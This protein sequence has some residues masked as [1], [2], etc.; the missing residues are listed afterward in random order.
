MSI[1]DLILS[2][3][4]L[5]NIVFDKKQEEDNILL[6]IGKQEIKLRRVFAEFISPRIS[7]IR[8]CDPT[9][10]TID[11]T[12]L[13]YDD[14]VDQL[15]QIFTTKLINIMN[16]LSSGYS[17]DLDENMISNFLL[18]SVILGN[19]ELY[20]KIFDKLTKE[21]DAIQIDEIVKIIQYFK[22]YDSISSIVDCN[23]YISHIASHFHAIDT[24]KLKQLQLSTLYLILRD[25]HLK[26]KSE[27]SLLDFIKEVL[28]SCKVESDEMESE[29]RKKF[30]EVVD[31][32]GLS[33]E[34]FSEFI[35]QLTVSEISEKLWDLL[36]KLIKFGSFSKVL[37]NNEP[38]GRFKGIIHKLG[39]GNSKSVIDNKI[40]DF[41]S[42]SV[43]SSMELY[44]PSSAIE[45]ENKSGGYY[46]HSKEDD[47][48]TWLCFDFKERKVM[49]THYSLKSLAS[50]KQYYNIQSWNIEGSND[51]TKWEVLDS[52]QNEK[53]LDDKDA[54][55]TFEITNSS[56]FYR[57]LRI[58][59]TGPNTYKN[60]DY[61]FIIRS[62]E[63]FGIIQED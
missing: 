42:S 46:F 49:P 40:V 8:Q 34:K 4:G 41:T 37:Y 13:I 5:K 22:D 19:S 30:F 35:D 10:E 54:S 12:G 29:V 55:N 2:S 59:Q 3:A 32:N 20:S 23:S 44:Q 61:R 15:S 48:D 52:R 1:K 50:S 36:K 26:V 25:E 57:Y 9:I 21:K 28:S 47:K 7:R 60:T 62:I 31:I 53:S 45:Y 14:K 18:V 33:K 16:Q 11:L 17:I 38:N 39:N 6:I 63:Y 58:H 24:D 27:D 43:T 56:D 51:G